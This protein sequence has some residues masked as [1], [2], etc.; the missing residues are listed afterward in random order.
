MTDALPVGERP[1]TADRYHT[2]EL[3]DT[4]TRTFRIPASGWIEAPGELL[5]L[6]EELS[7]PVE[8]KRRIGSYLLWRAGP[9]I[10]E[11]WYMAVDA[12][13]SDRRYRFRLHGKDGVGLGP[14]GKTHSRFRSW[15]EALLAGSSL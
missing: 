10:G 12:S 9:P 11:A 6:G 4:P 15:K 3:P 8:Y 2:S 13:N 14:D 5:T 1:F 7:E